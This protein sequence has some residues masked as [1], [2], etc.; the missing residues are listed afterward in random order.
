M[1]DKRCVKL[2]RL[3]SKYWNFG[4]TLAAAAGLAHVTLATLDFKY[5]FPSVQT[6]GQNRTKKAEVAFCVEAIEISEANESLQPSS[7]SSDA[8]IANAVREAAY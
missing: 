1:R 5:R 7:G 4:T 8:K 6:N 2:P 3:G